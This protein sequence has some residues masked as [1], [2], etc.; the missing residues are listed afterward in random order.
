VKNCVWS[1]CRPSS[2]EGET[3]QSLG[4]LAS[5]LSLVGELLVPMILTSGAHTH[6]RTHTHT[7]THTHSQQVAKYKSVCQWPFMDFVGFWLMVF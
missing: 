3:G 1:V 2:G 7:H 5:Q 4:S 6:T